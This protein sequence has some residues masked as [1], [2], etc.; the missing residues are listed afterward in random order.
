MISFRLRKLLFILFF[1]FLSLSGF[2]QNFERYN[3]YF[4]SS[5]QAIRFNRTSRVATMVSKA[6]PFSTGGSATASDP[7]NANLLFYTDGANVYDA[8]NLRMPQ[9]LGLTAN[10][11]ANQPVVI[12]AVPGQNNK[13]FIFTNTAN[14][15]TGGTISVSVVD[16]GLFGNAL[17]PAPALGDIESKNTAIGLANRAEGMVIIPHSN[18]TDFW[19]I[20]QQVSSTT[21]TATLINAASYT[22]TY[23]HTSVAATSIPTTAANLAYHAGKKKIAVSAQDP[24]TDAIILDFNNTTGAITFDRFIFNSGLP[25]TTGQSIYDIEWSITGDYLYLS[26]YGEP[27]IQADLLQYDYQNPST[28]LNSVLPSPVFRSYGVQMA[29]D[30]SIYHLYQAASGGPILLGKFSKADTIASQVKYKTAQ[31]TLTDLAGTQ[32]PAFSPK[33]KVNLTVNFT[34]AGN[35]QNNNT[36]FFPDVQ[37]G[38][39]KL[40]WDFGDGKDTVAWGP[41]HKYGRPSAFNVTLT[42]YYQGDSAKITQAVTINPFSLILNLV[43]DTTAC[44]P[45]FPPKRGQSKPKQF[46]VKASVTGGTPTSYT[47]SNGDTGPIL[48]PDS[49]GYYYVV[50]KDASGCS[51]YAGVNVKEYKLQDQRKNVW[52]FGTHAGI[53]FTPNPPKALSNSAMDAPEGCAVVCD[54][55]GKAIFYTD[56]DKVY[57]KTDALIATGIGG[58][59]LAAQSSI[60]VPVPGDETLYYIFTNQAING[61]S[62]NMVMWSLFD[63]K[64]NNGLGA[65]VKQAQPLFAKSTERITASAKWLIIHEYGNNTFRAYPISNAGIGD[66]VLTAIGSDHSSTDPAQGDGYMK[67]GPKN[68]LAVALSVPGTGNF[69]E[70][71]HLN[72]STG[73]ITSYRKIDLKEPAG[74]VYGVEFSPGG[75][76]LFATVKG[77]PS[78]S[79]VFE[80]FIDSLGHPYLRQ[81]PIQQNAE[82]GEI[83]IG[84]DNQLY[85]AINDSGV[86]GTIQATDDTTKLSVINFNGFTLAAGTK[87]KLGLPNFIHQENNA[88]GGPSADITGVC[89]GSPTKFNG[90]PTDAIDQML[91]F[92]GDGGSD[93]QGTTQHTYAAAGKYNVTLRVT[94]R[95]GLDTTLVKLLTIVPPPAKPTIPGAGALCTG[96]VTLNANTGNLPGLSYL[97]STGQTTQ[98]IVVNVQSIVSVTITDTNGCTSNGQSLVADNQPQVDIGPDQTLCQNSF[99]LALNAQNPGATFAWTVNGGSATTSQSRPLDTTLPGVF[100][101]KVVVTDPITTCT[102][103]DQATFTIVASPSF[104]LGGTNP[105]TCNGTDGTLIITLVTTTPATGPYSYFLTGPGAFNQQAIDQTAP[106]TVTFNTLPAGVYSGVVSDQV[107]GCTISQSF[108]LSSAPPGSATAAPITFCDPETVQI[109]TS[110]TFPVQYQATNNATGVATALASAAGPSPFNMSTPLSAGTYT[111]Q[112]TDNVGCITSINNFAVTPNAPVNVTV[113]PGVCSTPPT[114]TAAGGATNYSWSGPGIVGPT[115]GPTITVSGQGQFTYTVTGSGPGVCPNTQSTTVV[116]DNPTPDFTQSDPCQPSVILTASPSGNYTYR[117]YKGGT[118]QPALLGQNISLGL[119]ENLASYQTELFNTLNGCAYKS[120]PKTISINGVVDAT[121]SATPA[122][123]DGKPFILTATTAAAGVTFTW[124]KNGTVITGETKSTT[125]QT[126]VATYKVDVAKGTCKATSQLAVTRAPLPVGQLA[127]RVIICNDPENTDPKTNQVDLDPGQFTGYNWFKNELTLNYV[128]RVYT[129][130][131][132]GKYRVDLTNSFGCVAPDEIEVLNECLPRIDAPNAFRPG[133][134]VSNPLDPAYKNSEFW[135]LTSFIQDNSFSIFI[136]NRWGDLVFTSSD[137]FFRWKGDLQNNGQ[138]LPGGAYAYV[139][140]YVSSFHPERGVQEKRGGVVLLK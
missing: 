7:G 130:T 134:T 92:F 109:T 100:T 123:D 94:N 23:T 1:G 35:C 135:V 111:I 24:S 58:D 4:G 15:T 16:M 28:T 54:R 84:P 48:T 77:T 13:Y 66:P 116:L 129:A 106:K 10:S 104:T 60:I 46:S 55:N 51:T 107:S 62:A 108:G 63:L 138:L 128:Q 30:S 127:N 42:A 85:I 8:S 118:F 105:T 49:A 140:K 34:F 120:N 56:G 45:E 11:S 131:S 38:A 81:P 12:C 18:G 29:P 19:L 53:D 102:A 52:Y 82:L 67:L 79:K 101:Y 99:T 68:Q 110:L 96:P 31:L 32:F 121:L 39:D 43:Q 122:C 72:D 69:V 47:W 65:V 61:T 41:I 133:S 33:A 75:N 119:S 113:T 17:F 22:G 27:G 26:R 91:W 71:F 40:K 97:W 80:Y 57:D 50:V 25:T 20:T 139:V 98:T 132:Q 37:P 59:P 88:F 9:G 78:P 137:R 21:F 87:S 93:N 44:R 126:D 3:W 74:N 136:Y 64:Q 70:L 125:S 73:K 36:A 2:S 115:N 117:W 95:C 124:Y 83:Q 112:L 89:L 6:I 76:K 86:L 103:T 5:T 114:L 14:F 90:T